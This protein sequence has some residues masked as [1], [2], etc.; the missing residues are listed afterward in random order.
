MKCDDTALGYSKELVPKVLQTMAG[1][2]EQ[3]A[4][5]AFLGA[6]TK[7]LQKSTTAGPFPA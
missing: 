1:P 6:L 5:G 7:Q 4:G 2:L 3:M